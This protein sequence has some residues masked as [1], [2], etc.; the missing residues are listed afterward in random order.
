M[1]TERISFDGR[2]ARKFPVAFIGDNVEAIA[3]LISRGLSVEIFHNSYIDEETGEKHWAHWDPSMYWVWV[4][5]YYLMVLID[6][7]YWAFYPSYVEAQ[8][9][10][11]EPDSGSST[12]TFEDMEEIENKLL[13]CAS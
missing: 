2:Y 13:A 7:K 10:A 8:K 5:E 11:I 3:D 12:L 6:Q 4:D 1:Q 9:I